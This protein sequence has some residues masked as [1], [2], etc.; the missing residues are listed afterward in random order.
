MANNEYWDTP[1]I[2]PSITYTDLPRAIEWLQR[3]FG[4]RERSDARLS[5]PGGGM[6]WFEVGD[7]LFHIT[8]SDTSWPQAARSTGCFKIK[9]YVEDVDGHFA[10]AM[11][12]GAEIVS[13][14]ED[15]FWG[16]RIYRALDHEGNRWE[17]SQKG[18]D[19]AAR[20]WR[21]P[22]GVTRGMGS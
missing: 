18:R 22:P 3:V 14:P 21:L 12:R 4:F 9:I 20:Q 6:A 15:G 8:T 17:I 5:W 11:A 16:G 2:V 19:L 13:E 1:D 10:H 7:S